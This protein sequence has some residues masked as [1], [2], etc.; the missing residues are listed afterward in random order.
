[1]PGIACCGGSEPGPSSGCYAR[2]VVVTD[3]YLTTTPGRAVKSQ[4][5]RQVITA[6]SARHGSPRSPTGSG[7][8]NTVKCRRTDL[9]GLAW[10][11][12][13]R[14][15]LPLDGFKMQTAGAM[16]CDSH[17]VP[18]TERRASCRGIIVAHPELGCVNCLNP[19]P[20]LDIL[21]NGIVGVRAGWSLPARALQVV[22]CCVI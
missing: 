22:W 21:T 12:S 17:H 15:A 1:M 5:R 7:G 9:E 6:R 14:L 13:G 18:S 2:A 4:L 20:C 8:P 11:P 3:F 19:G 10:G 16:A